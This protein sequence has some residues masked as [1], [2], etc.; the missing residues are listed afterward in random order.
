MGRSQC[1]CFVG[2]RFELRGTAATEV[3]PYAPNGIHRARGDARK[4][5]RRLP[6]RVGRHKWG[7]LDRHLHPRSECPY[8]TAKKTSFEWRYCKLCGPKGLNTVD[9][10]PSVRA[11]D[12][13]ALDAARVWQGKTPAPPAGALVEVSPTDEPKRRAKALQNESVQR[14]SFSVQKNHNPSGEIVLSEC[15]FI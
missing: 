3:S 1:L 10:L 2:N 9:I 4:P 12:A 5:F 6:A 15:L 8:Y 7:R 11:V 14:T 13:Q